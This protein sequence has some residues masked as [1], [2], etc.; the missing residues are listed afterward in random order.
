VL[1]VK[2]YY[3]D[4]DDDDDDDDNT[5]KV[6]YFFFAYIA[7]MLVTGI[8]T[9]MDYNYA[10]P[11]ILS[12]ISSSATAESTSSSLPF[13]VGAVLGLGGYSLISN[14][15]RQ[16]KEVDD[17]DNDDDDTASQPS[18]PEKKLM[19]L[20]DQQLLLDQIESLNSSKQKHDRE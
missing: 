18:S 16:D 2:D 8:L 12:S 13:I 15:Y 9:P 11:E 3:D 7:S 10:V 6:Y 4:D 5:I 17:D 20:W 14:N 1:L 19:N